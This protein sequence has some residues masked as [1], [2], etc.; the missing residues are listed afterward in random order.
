[1][2]LPNQRYVLAETILNDG[3]NFTVTI[4]NQI[5]TI[6]VDGKIHSEFDM[7]MGNGERDIQIAKHVCAYANEMV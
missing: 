1:M 5:P 7:L 6:E 4:N 2:Y 3:R